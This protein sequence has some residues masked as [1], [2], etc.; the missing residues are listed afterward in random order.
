MSRLSKTL[1]GL[2]SLARNPWLFNTVLAADEPAWQRRALA[3]PARGVT[4]LG[5]PAVPLT[6]FLSAA[7]EM[8]R[9]FAFGDG[10]SLPT[11]LLLLRALARRVPAARSFTGLPL[12]IPCPDC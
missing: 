1:R 11:D 9:P 6:A 7:D 3:H 4:P 5:L 2:L 12:P 10:G 8:V